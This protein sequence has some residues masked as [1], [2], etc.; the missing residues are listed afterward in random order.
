MMKNC[1]PIPVKKMFSVGD[2]GDAESRC[3]LALDLL[4]KPPLQPSRDDRAAAQAHLNAALSA[5]QEMNASA[6]IILVLIGCARW[7][8]VSGRAQAAEQV[9]AGVH[10]QTPISFEARLWLAY[11][12]FEAAPDAVPTSDL[13]HGLEAVVALMLTLFVA[14]PQG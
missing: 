10:Q 14:P 9:L 1:D 11:F 2:F 7:C 13:G 6:L 12:G 3:A 8:A 4:G 5:A